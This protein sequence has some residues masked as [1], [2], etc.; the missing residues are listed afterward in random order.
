MAIPV[1]KRSTK[2][3]KPSL[4]GDTLKNYLDWDIAEDKKQVIALYLEYKAGMKIINTFLKSLQFAMPTNEGH[5]LLFGS[6]NITATISGRLSSSNPNLQNL[7]AKG[8]YGK[9]IKDCFISPPGYL[10]G[11]ADFNSLE[12]YVSA[13]QT[14]DPN[15]LKVYIEGYDGHSLRA[16]YYYPDKLGHLQET[17]ESINTIKENFEEWRQDSKAPT[18]ALTYQGTYKTLMTN[19]GWPKDKA[20]AVEANYKKLYQVSIDWVNNKLDQAIKDGFVTLA[21]GLRLLTP[22]LHNSDRIKKSVTIVEQERRSAGNALGQSYC[23]L[24]NRAALAFMQKVWADPV[25]RTKIFPAIFIHDAS[26]FIWKNSPK[27]TKFVND[28]LIQEM[29]WQELPDIQHDQVKLGAELDIYY[30]SWKY[31]HT[32]KNNLSLQDIETKLNVT[33]LGK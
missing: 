22:A 30:P 3:K 14:K 6:F 21:F 24:N 32:L 9:I 10:F 7:P 18:F 8:Q 19:L 5:A 16:Y 13:L 20:L 27:V 1:V 2:T 25:M 28:N 33:I 4:E 15:K 26:Y 23:M 11:G 12:D 31:P 17:P 29:R